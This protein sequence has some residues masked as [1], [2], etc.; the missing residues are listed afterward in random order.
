MNERRALPRPRRPMGAGR[1][2][3]AVFALLLM[4][5]MPDTTMHSAP[6]SDRAL[7]PAWSAPAHRPSAIDR[8]SVPM[9]RVR[10]G[11]SQPSPSPP[12]LRPGDQFTIP[13]ITSPGVTTTCTLAFPVVDSLGRRYVT[14][15][16]HCVDD[17]EPTYRSPDGRSWTFPPGA[18]P[19][20]Y[21]PPDTPADE[22]TPAPTGRHMGSLVY[23]KHH[24]DVH[25]FALILLDDDVTVEPILR[26]WDIPIQDFEPPSI[27]DRVFLHGH[28]LVISEAAPSRVG[29]V[30]G[31]NRVM[32]S[33]SLVGIHGDSGAPLVGAEGQ[34]LGIIHLIGGPADGSS[35]G[36]LSAFRWDV[37]LADARR[38]LGLRLRLVTA[39]PSAAAD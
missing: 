13:Q 23:L 39:E 36:T 14:T 20:I 21:Y 18:R 25:D 5:A 24:G 8:H 3:A 9:G 28:G 16:G 12:V 30:T 31:T 10:A 1:A 35:T 27:G 6:D 37:G 34:A 38:A 17:Q 32:T 22:E 26:G 2:A 19:D 29:V 4:A 33:T 15:A 11:T 7:G